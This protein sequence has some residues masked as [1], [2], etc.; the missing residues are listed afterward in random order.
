MTGPT[1]NLPEE[2]RKRIEE[3]KRE[4]VDSEVRTLEG[5]IGTGLESLVAEAQT[6]L[7]PFGGA[8][9]VLKAAARFVATRSA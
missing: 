1:A 7:G 3:K 6:A 2:I 4:A 8:A 9:D 5:L